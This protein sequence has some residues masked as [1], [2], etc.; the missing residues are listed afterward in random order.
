MK[1][2]L[3]ALFIMCAL[4]MP[5]ITNAY[6]TGILDTTFASGLAV[7]SG[8][9]SV[10]VQTDG[11]ILVVGDFTE[12]NGVSR[13][14]IA[15]INTDGTLDTT[16]NPGQGADMTIITLA[17]QKD[18]K[19]LIGGNFTSYNGVSRNRIA[20]INTDGTLDTTFNPG[21]GVN[22]E[23]RSISIQS[24]GKLI[25]AGY[26]TTF[27]GDIA[28][29][30]ILRLN[31]DGT[32]DSSFSAGSGPTY[33]TDMYNGYLYSTL[34]QSDGKIVIA[35]SFNQYDNTAIN[36]IARLNTDG[37]LDPAFAIGSGPNGAVLGAS[38]Q[39]DGKLIIGGVF[40]SYNGVSRNRIAR[41][42]TDGT[43]DTTF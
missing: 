36:N 9:T 23:V 28:A 11:K 7:G 1:K 20:R 15:R 24:D 41:I 42:N 4:V 38:L 8:A 21:Q 29:S 5:A 37:T 13:N 14:R 31:T 34:V 6:S 32:I 26:F 10:A 22:G 12:Y 18:G 30:R 16:F 19:I 40:T 43:L 3:V 35:G 27:D 33:P 39:S 2:K 25:V 17:L